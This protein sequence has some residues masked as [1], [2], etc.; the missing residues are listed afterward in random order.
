MNKTTSTD[1]EELRKEFEEG[2]RYTFSAPI[3]DLTTKKERTG[4]S[5]LLSDIND[6]IIRQLKYIYTFFAPHLSNKS[7]VEKEA[8]GEFE[9]MLFHHFMDCPSD[10]TYTK[11]DIKAV[12]AVVLNEYLFSNEK[13]ESGVK[14]DNA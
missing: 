6:I 3:V 5:V 12:L 2:F 4:Q 14:R 1:I 10:T 8:V 7:E 9:E 11:S 13:E